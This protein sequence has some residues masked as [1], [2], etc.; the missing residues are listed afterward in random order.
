MHPVRVGPHP[1]VRYDSLRRRI[2]VSNSGT[3]VRLLDLLASLVLIMQSV[4]AF[5]GLRG[6][7]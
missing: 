6:R 1:D 2:E 7:Y 3:T 5:D 4:R